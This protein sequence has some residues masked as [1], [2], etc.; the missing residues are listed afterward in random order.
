M[1]TV[2]N[3]RNLLIS[4][5][6][7]VKDKDTLAAIDQLLSNSAT[8]QKVELTEEQEAMLQMS[9][10]DL[11]EGKTITHEELFE[12]ELKWLNEQ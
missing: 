8:H 11:I 9:E 12:R 1:T 4:K 6:L 10:K 2:E 3:L 5:I 7:T